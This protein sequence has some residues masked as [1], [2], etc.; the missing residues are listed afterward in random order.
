MTVV[1]VVLCVVVGAL[2]LYAGKQSKDQAREFAD[3]IEE[4]RE[5]V[6]KQNG[7]LVTVGE[8]LTAELSRVK[9]DVLPGL[10]DRLRRNSGQIEELST[11]LRQAD[12]YIKAQATRLHDL[13]QQRVTLAALRRKL[14]DLES[15]VRSAPP[16]EPPAGRRLDTALDRLADLERNGTE[17]L[18]LQRDL[19][20]TLEDVE[21]VVSDLLHYAGGELDEAVRA[22][23]RGGRPGGR[24]LVPGRLWARDPRLGDVLTD[25]YERCLHTVGLDVRLRTGEGEPGGPQRQRF[26]LSG[27]SPEDLAGGFTSLLISTGT[28]LS[29]A[30]LLPT[31]VRV[32]GAPHPAD[33]PVPPDEAALKA[34]LR[35]MY[36]SDGATTQIGPLLA[37]R[38][39]EE[40]LCAV[41]TPGQSL[42]LENDE[43]FWDPAATAL[44]LRQMAAH[45]VW[46]L[47]D[48]AGQLP[49][50]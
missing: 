15:T 4:L 38:T 8:Q 43:V 35:A 21:D 25:V 2:E 44:R 33:R 48:W 30:A 17:I 40:L 29:R 34:L 10:D 7:V 18:E 27:R 39:R 31:D 45:Q 42:E 1:L 14:T 6:S 13:E 32:A 46:E 26:F 22:S 28:D 47:T 41:L 11:L 9:R 19:T 20:R 5:Q 49:T 3:R 37:V 24:A 50:T 23:L 16:Q 36:D 12:D